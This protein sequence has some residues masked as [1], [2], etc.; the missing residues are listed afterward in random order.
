MSDQSH[1][2]VRFVDLYLNVS[3]NISLSSIVTPKSLSSAVWEI[4]CSVP[5][6]I[7]R[8][9]FVFGLCFPKCMVLHIAG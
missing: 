5:P 1:C 4:S 6:S 9:Y 7:G 3:R 8:V 2:T